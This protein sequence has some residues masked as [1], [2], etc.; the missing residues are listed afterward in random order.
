MKKQIREKKLYTGLGILQLFISV[1]AIPAGLG[2]ILDPSGGNLA[3]TT[4]LIQDSPFGSYLIPGIILFTVNGI[5]SLLGSFVSF[6]KHN[7]AG[8]LSMVLGLALIIWIIAQVYWMGFVSWLQPFIFIL[9][10]IE[11]ILAINLK[12][13]QRDLAEKNKISI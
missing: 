5:G 10:V 13:N 4:D 2:F 11:L 12:N 1:A 3:M 7:S 8:V 9:G 6:Y